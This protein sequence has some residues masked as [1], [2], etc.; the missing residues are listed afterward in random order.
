[1]SLQLSVV[2][3]NYN[4]SNY[5]EL[6]LSSVKRAISGIPAEIIIVDNAS[7]DNSLDML[8]RKHPELSVIKNSDNFGF[9][10]GNNQGVANAKGKYICIL[11]PDTVLPEDCFETLLAF[12][13]KQTDMGAIGPQLIDGSG[14]FLPE[15]KRNLPTPPVALTKILSSDRHY[16]NHQIGVEDVG[17]T[18]VLVGAFMFIKRKVYENFGGFDED[19]FMYGEDIDLSYRLNKAGLSNLYYGALKMI[20]FKGESTLKDETYAKHFYGAMAIFYKKHFKKSAWQKTMVDGLVQVARNLSFFRQKESSDYIC[21]LPWLL[22][23]ADRD[24]IDLAQTHFGENLNIHTKLGFPNLAFKESNLIF[25]AGALAYKD[26]IMGMS[27]LNKFG[28]KF[29]IRP[30][31]CNFILGSDQ[32]ERRG[33]I[34]WLD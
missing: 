19:Y 23:S 32:S 18:T 14:N 30:P 7:T 34:I 24:F 22:L 10:K 17:E 29:Y 20:H 28:N 6:C 5:L 12:A 33:Q 27:A 16:Y 15:S 1:M 26:I 2:I 3:L 31:G 9:A 21:N 4:V 25:D 8:S 11:N 13:E